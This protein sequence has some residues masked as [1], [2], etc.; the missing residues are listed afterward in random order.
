MIYIYKNLFVTYD[1]TLEQRKLTV[2]VIYFKLTNKYQKVFQDISKPQVEY[3]KKLQFF[4][5]SRSSNGIELLFRIKFDIRAEDTHNLFERQ[6]KKLGQKFR[7]CVGIYIPGLT[8]V[9]AG[10]PGLSGSP[11]SGRVWPFFSFPRSFGL[12]GPVQAPG[13]PG[14]GST[15]RSFGFNNTD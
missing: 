7:R 12:P 9:R 13:R 11:G 15:R 3:K 8:R 14:P 5:V 6:R 10:H 4:S 1:S 2:E